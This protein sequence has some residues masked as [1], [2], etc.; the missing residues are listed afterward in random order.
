MNKHIKTE[1]RGK[2]EELAR[3][4]RRKQSNV[5]PPDVISNDRGV[6]DVLWNGPTSSNLVQR[7]GVF[8]IGFMLL[9]CGL[10]S[11]SIFYQKGARLWLIPNGLIAAGGL[12]AIYV[13]LKGRSVR[14]SL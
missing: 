12:R 6:D 2:L 13:S 5:L 7:V 9:S 14:K 8:L 11:A 10:A 1:E 3:D 4:L